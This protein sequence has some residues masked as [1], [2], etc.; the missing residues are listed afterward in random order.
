[1]KKNLMRVGVVVGAVAFVLF[2]FMSLTIFCG[3]ITELIVMVNDDTLERKEKYTQNFLSIADGKSTEVSN[4]FDFEFD[5]AFVFHDCYLTGDGFSSL[6]DDS[7]SIEE[8]GDGSSEQFMRIVFV[9]ENGEFVYEFGYDTTEI[10]FYELGLVIY[11]DTKV[12]RCE[13]LDDWG[14]SFKFDSDEYYVGEDD[15]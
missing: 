15:L 12:E 5:R 13:P 7:V 6:Y 4:I 10:D 2:M 8:V 3:L 14:V 11:P 9:D 1:M